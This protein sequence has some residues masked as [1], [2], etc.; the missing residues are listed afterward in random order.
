L[1]CGGGDVTV[2]LAQRASRERLEVRFAGCDASPLAISLARKNAQDAGYNIEFFEA[3]VLTAQLPVGFDAFICSLFLHHL[4]DGDAEDL[5]RR[6]SQVVGSLILV[7]D[8]VR[9]RSG[10]L[11]AW[12]ACHLLTDSPIV[13]TDGPLSV[14]AAFTPAEAMVLATRAGL[15]GT[16][17]TRHWPL[18]MLLQW[19]K[20]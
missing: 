13:R 15:G 17:I 3:D 7:N 2:A 1:A 16:T 9:S 19:W 14:K 11:L 8:L 10:Y 5:L 4:P 6:M 18:R 20:P 12:T